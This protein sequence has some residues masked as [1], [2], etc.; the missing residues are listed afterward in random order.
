MLCLQKNGSEIKSVDDWFKFAPPKKGL[1]H[2]K[3]GRSAKELAKAW[4]PAEGNPIVPD[5]LQALLESR[6]ETRGIAFEQGE[7]ERVIL[8]DTCG[9]GRHADLVL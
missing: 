8:F 9:E 2:W 6:D 4:F 1:Y 5:E 7:P 3:D